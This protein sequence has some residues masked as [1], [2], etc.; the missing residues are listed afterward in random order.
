M[1]GLLDIMLISGGDITDDEFRELLD[2][3]EELDNGPEQSIQAQ[4]GENQ[5]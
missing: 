4:E 5:T 3:Y 2:E 1:L